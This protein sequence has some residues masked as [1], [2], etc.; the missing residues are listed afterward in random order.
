MAL[1]TR[2]TFNAGSAFLRAIQYISVV[3]RLLTSVG[4]AVVAIAIWRLSSNRLSD[5]LAVIGIAVSYV[6]FRL[7]LQ[8]IL[9]Q[10]TIDKVES[11]F[12]VEERNRE[13]LRLILDRCLS[14]A[15]TAD[16][17]RNLLQTVDAKDVLNILYALT[18]D[19]QKLS[20]EKGLSVAQRS[21]A[22]EIFKQFRFILDSIETSGAFDASE[23][24]KTLSELNFTVAAWS[25]AFGEEEV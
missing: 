10:E 6:G 15:A 9:E 14:V 1:V 4:L 18:V 8:L 5:E 3:E 24:R 17:V 13:R 11:R 21:V 22:V 25:D 12:E 7:A 19:V 23:L 16:T 20:R 2:R